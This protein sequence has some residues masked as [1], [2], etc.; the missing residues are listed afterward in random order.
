MARTSSL[1][2]AI[3]LAAGTHTALALGKTDLCDCPALDAAT[4]GF[5][6]PCGTTGETYVP[7]ENPCI[8]YECGEIKEWSIIVVDC[9]PEPAC[10]DAGGTYFPPAE[11]QCCGNCE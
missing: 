2:V 8:I 11:G 4:N 6:V 5:D 7:P 1:L 3:A 10:I 9:F